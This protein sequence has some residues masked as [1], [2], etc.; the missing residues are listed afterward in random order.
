MPDGS[1]QHG[2]VERSIE[3][4]EIVQFERFGFARKSED[5]EL[6]YTHG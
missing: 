1:K 6:Y 4:G 5:E 2:K 3:D